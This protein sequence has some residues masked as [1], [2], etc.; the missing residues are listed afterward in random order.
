M[1]VERR[2]LRAGPLELVFDDGDLRRLRLG[3]REVLRRIYVA[4]RDRNWGTVPGR[5]ENFALTQGSDSFSIVYD[6]I[7]QQNEID[8]RW[9]ATIAGNSQGRI[10]FAMAGRAHSTFFRN[11][12]GFC[13]HHPLKG[14]AGQPC[15]VEKADGRIERGVFPEFVSPHQPFLDIRSIT[16][17]VMP[18]VEA[19]VRFTGEVFEM[20]DHRNWTD[21]NFKTYGTPLALPFPVEVKAGTEINQVVDLSI[22]GNAPSARA[23]AEPVR[24][25]LAGARRTKLPA[26]GVCL[27]ASGGPLTDSTVAR[28]K[29]LNLSHLRVDVKSEDDWRMAVE[30][31]IRLDVKLEAAITL[32]CD[33]GYLRANPARVLRWLVFGANE[34]CTSAATLQAARKALGGAAPLAAGTNAY[35]AELNRNRPQGLAIDGACFSINPQVHAFF[36]ESLMDNVAAQGDVVRSAK[37]FLGGIPVV[38][39]PVTLRPRFNPDATAAS[40]PPAPDPRQRT[41]FCAAWT[42]GSLKHLSEAGAS[43]VTYYEAVGAR[44]LLDERGVFP[45]YRVLELAAGFAGQDVLPSESSD[46]GRVDSIVLASGRRRRTVVANLTGVRQKARVEIG[47]GH[48][49]ELAAYAVE[50]ID[51]TAD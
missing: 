32:P 15:V 25:H 19:Q 23:N 34:R 35:F 46:A 31:S 50:M 37:Q 43:S 9:R 24:V 4:V 48:S 6:S 44:G 49:L 40:E 11:R 29:K 21:A 3:D 5:I 47:R 16:H 8:F 27:S 41:Q 7:H 18:G 2:V 12:I 38:V 42:V 1:N 30:A 51:W 22:R 33:T 45:V 28:L 13:V 14:C 26:L 36:D 10:V 39:S 17:P 20:E